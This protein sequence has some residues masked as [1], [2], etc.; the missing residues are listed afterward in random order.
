[1]QKEAYN[2]WL[3]ANNQWL[4]AVILHWGGLVAWAFTQTK[5]GCQRVLEERGSVVDDV[6]GL[7]CKKDAQNK[8]RTELLLAREQ[9]RVAARVKQE[10]T[11]ALLSTSEMARSWKVQKR[12]EAHSNNSEAVSRRRGAGHSETRF[13]QRV[14]RRW[15][16]CVHCATKMC[17][18]WGGTMEV[19]TFVAPWGSLMRNSVKNKHTSDC[20]RIWKRELARVMLKRFDA[21]T[22]TAV[23]ILSHEIKYKTAHQWSKC[24][25]VCLT[26]W[27]FTVTASHCRRITDSGIAVVHCQR[28]KNLHPPTLCPILIQQDATVAIAC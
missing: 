14:W 13:L 18:Q 27:F 19:R 4:Y 11:H 23:Q 21:L 2:K 7:N 20:G 9:V 22:S 24:V 28:L 3:E 6:G 16:E 10:K 1:M 17:V 8:R 26:Y 25:R 5:V 12:M 15:Q